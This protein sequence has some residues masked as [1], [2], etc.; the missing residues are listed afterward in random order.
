MAS[1]T[2]KSKKGGAMLYMQPQEMINEF[3]K[4]CLDYEERMDQFNKFILT[5]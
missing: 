3:R 1:H 2:S 4:K 5:I